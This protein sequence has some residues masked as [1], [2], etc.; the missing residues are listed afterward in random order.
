MGEGFGDY[1][2]GSFFAEKKP[3][4]YRDAVITWD[5]LLIGLE[6]GSTPPCLRPLKSTLTYHDFRKRGDEHDNGVIWAAT[7]WDIRRALG[8]KRADTIIV[9]S[10]FQ[11]DGFTTFARGA[12]AILDADRNLNLGRNVVRLRRIFRK[13]RIGPL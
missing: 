1:F 12:R 5:G 9:E 8:R 6:E 11:L 13:R 3:K 4:R 2:A 10:H 7:L